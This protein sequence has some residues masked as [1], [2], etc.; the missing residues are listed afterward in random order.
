VMLRAM[1]SEQGLHRSSQRA[2]DALATLLW[3]HQGD[4]RAASRCWNC[5]WLRQN[6]TGRACG[7]LTW[8][9]PKTWCSASSCSMTS[10]ERNTSNLIPP[11]ISR[12]R[13]LRP[14]RAALYWLHECLRPA[15]TRC[16]F[17]R[18]LVRFA[19]EDVGLAQPNALLIANAA[20][21]AVHFIGMPK[22]TP[23]WHSVSSI[24]RS[25]PS[26]TRSTSPTAGE[27]GRA[28]ERD[29]AGAAPSPQRA[30]PAR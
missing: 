20:K 1:A 10:R 16:T 30:G 5:P 13:G 7:V 3:S 19:S 25:R 18:R 11:C 28:F 26:P 12:W 14:G 24:S 27:R 6:R 4:A 22:A 15:K 21:D 8:S 23:R 2:E 29:R 9:L 17:A